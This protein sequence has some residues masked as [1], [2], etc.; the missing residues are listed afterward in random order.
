[1]RFK[2]CSEATCDKLSLLAALSMLTVL[3]KNQQGGLKG[4]EPLAYRRNVE[5][6]H[7]ENYA[8]W[9]PDQWDHLGSSM[10]A[11]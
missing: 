10:R 6:K 4:L 5:E 1:V 8:V 9:V 11:G 3:Q 7:T 2:L